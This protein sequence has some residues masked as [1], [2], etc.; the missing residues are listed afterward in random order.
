M[1]T[2]NTALMAATADDG[3]VLGDLFTATNTAPQVPLVTVLTVAGDRTTSDFTL[4][5]ASG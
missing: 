1:N 5:I 2:L 4:A 3:T